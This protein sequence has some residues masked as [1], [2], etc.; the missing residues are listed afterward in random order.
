MNQIYRFDTVKAYNALNQHETLH[1]LV[2]IIDFSKA[3]LRSW[4]GQKKVRLAFGLYC[5]F[6][7]EV[8]CGDLKYGCNYYDYEEGTLVFVA[9]GQVMDIETDGKPYQ[10]LGHGL[11]FHPDLIRAS[12]LAKSMQDYRPAFRCLFC[13]SITFIC[14]LLWR[15]D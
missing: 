8:K 9:P 2:S 4:D 10:P 15:F 6:L 1:P 12:V 7:K 14:Q 5:V 3:N 11:V 13:R